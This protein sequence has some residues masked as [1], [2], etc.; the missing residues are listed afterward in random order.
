MQRVGLVAN[1]DKPAAHILTRRAAALI[2]RAGRSVVVDA[3]TGAC[4]GLKVPSHPGLH[5]LA[6]AC[7]MLVVIGGDGSMLR[8]ARSAA[9][10]GTPIL[11]I[12]AGALGFLTAISAEELPD[13]LRQVWAGGCSVESR[14]LLS[15]SRHG[16]GRRIRQVALNDIVISRGHVSRLIE[17]DV[18]VDGEFLTRFRCDGLIIST[19]TGSTAYSLAAGGAIVKPDADVMALTPICPHTLTNRSVLVSLRSLVQV[20]M[21]S[22]RLDSIL[23]ADGQ[24]QHTLRPGDELAVRRSRRVVKL[25]RLA[26]SSFFETLRRKLRWSGSSV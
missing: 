6:A 16:P 19:P 20:R 7:D 9:E 5:E 23:S 17:L 10:A 18:H 1:T 14:A 4:T 12:N 26:Q 2:A 22:D 8:V 11:G 3:A 21:V 24:I 13:A 15:V 25:I